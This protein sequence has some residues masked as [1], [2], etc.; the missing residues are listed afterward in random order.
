MIHSKVLNLGIITSDGRFGITQ[1]RILAF[2]VAAGQNATT[3]NKAR[4]LSIY[5]PM[6][7]VVDRL[8]V[9][10]GGTATGNVDIGIYEMESNVRLISTGAVA[11]SG[12]NTVQIISITP[13]LLK[14][15]KYWLGISHSSGSG[16]FF[17]LSIGATSTE[18]LVLKEELS[19]HPLPSTATPVIQSGDFFYP[20]CGMICQG[21]YN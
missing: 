14:A 7:V 8:F 3:A 15:G 13:V 17:A 16:T 9:L 2:P 6:P 18:V 20:I 12:T 4:Y 11:M 5:L 10:N 19:A 1:G 21:A